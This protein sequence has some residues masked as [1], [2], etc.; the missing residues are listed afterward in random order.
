M[1]LLAWLEEL[2]EELLEELLSHSKNS[3]QLH[4]VRAPAASAA[5]RIRAMGRLIRMT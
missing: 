5:D 4:P 1:G 2:E 3:S